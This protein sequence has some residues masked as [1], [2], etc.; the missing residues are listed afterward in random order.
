MTERPG[1]EEDEE[2]EDEEEEETAKAPRR[3]NVIMSNVERLKVQKYAEQMCGRFWNRYDT[4]VVMTSR[5]RV[6]RPSP[7]VGVASTDGFRS[8]ACTDQ[9]SQSA[10]LRLV[11]YMCP[12]PSRWLDLEK[13]REGPSAQSRTT[14]LEPNGLS[15]AC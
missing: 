13:G 2:E 14:P 5:L 4:T 12:R 7:F 15:R 6:V 3:R 9:S 11:P 10:R 8:M 1:E